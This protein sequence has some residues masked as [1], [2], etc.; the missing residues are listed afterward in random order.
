MK[1]INRSA[2]LTEDGIAREPQDC[3]VLSDVPNGWGDMSE[4]VKLSYAKEV[5]SFYIIR[6]W[7]KRATEE[8]DQL[9]EIASGR[10]RIPDWNKF[11]DSKAEQMRDVWKEIVDAFDAA[12]KKEQSDE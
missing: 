5:Y 4:D 9:D 11:M 12:I 6:L 7:I 1:P 3:V 10:T 2:F 8:E